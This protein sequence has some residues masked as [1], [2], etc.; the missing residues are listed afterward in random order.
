[1][2]DFDT[3]PRW[4]PAQPVQVVSFDCDATLSTLEGIDWLAEQTGHGPAVEALTYMAMRETGVN[5]SLY[6][7][8]LALVR[9][10]AGL[11]ERLT[12]AYCTH[13]TPDARAVIDVLKAAGK[14]VCV[15]SAGLLQA[16]QGFAV[17]LGVDP[18]HIGAV[19][20]I[21]SEHGEYVDYDGDSLFIEMSGKATWLERHYAGLERLHIGDGLNDV[22]VKEVGV[23]LI[24]FGGGDF[25]PQVARH[26]SRY[27]VENSLAPLLSLVLTQ[28]EIRALNP[29]HQQIIKKGDHIVRNRGVRFESMPGMGVC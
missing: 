8:R 17:W 5:A 21:F 18:A 16:V 3:I 22:R 11:L 26:C 12:E 7:D 9:P 14:T 23:H 2:G 28:E 15:L 20:L 25:Y 10:N 29:E 6:R 24:G 1:M 27:I 19:P 13:A 4:R